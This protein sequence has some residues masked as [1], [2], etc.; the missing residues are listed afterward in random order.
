MLYNSFLLF[1]V[2]DNVESLFQAQSTLSTDWVEYFCSVHNVPLYLMG[3]A[4]IFKFLH[5][6]TKY[7]F[8]PV[9]L[10]VES[11]VMLVPSF[12]EGSPC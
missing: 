12:L 1:K 6:S 11:G 9:V 5:M 4:L 2:A 10:P 8:V 3:L 7:C